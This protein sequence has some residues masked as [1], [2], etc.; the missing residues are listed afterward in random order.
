M[1]VGQ[2]AIGVVTIAQFGVGV[3]FGFGQFVTGL[4]VVGQF[5]AGVFLGLGQFS[6]G[7]VAIGQF[8]LRRL[9]A[10]LKWGSV[11]T[12]GAQPART[13]RPSSTFEGWPSSS[14]FSGCS[15]ISRTPRCRPRSGQSSGTHRDRYR[16]ARPVRRLVRGRPG[17]GRREAL[18]PQRFERAW[19]TNEPGPRPRDSTGTIQS[20]VAL[21]S[22][23][24][25]SSTSMAP[26]TSC[27]ALEM[28]KTLGA[29]VTVG[30]TERLGW[31]GRAQPST[32]KTSQTVS[33]TRTTRET[34]RGK[35]RRRLK[36]ARFPAG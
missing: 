29:T 28:T 16:P 20:A 11:A 4:S 2:Y 1:A 23:A 14:G 17:C 27:S 8:C 7:E 6:T 36:R 13:R 3:L 22:H 35:P 9:G 30:S 21:I 25:S 10:G 12:C 18:R 33:A 31:V 32:V 5:A 26:T 15:P 34:A 19:T 24:T